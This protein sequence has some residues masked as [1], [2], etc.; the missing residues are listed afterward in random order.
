MTQMYPA[1]GDVVLH[2]DTPAFPSARL[3]RIIAEQGLIEPILVDYDPSIGRLVTISADMGEKVMAALEC[4]FT[5]L[6]VE[7][8]YTQDDIS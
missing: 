2:E 7:D 6:L 4:N 3:V 1:I 5:D 8:E